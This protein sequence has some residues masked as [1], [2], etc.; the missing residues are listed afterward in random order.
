MITLAG[1]HQERVGRDHY[2]RD[3]VCDIISAPEHFSTPAHPGLFTCHADKLLGLHKISYR[4]KYCLILLTITQI[5]AQ[6]DLVS[7][8]A[9]LNINA[10][11]N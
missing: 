2:Y 3:I 1:H 7:Y 10:N 11:I 8:K 4:N 6:F 5:L 9:S